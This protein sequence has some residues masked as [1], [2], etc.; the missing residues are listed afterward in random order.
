MLRVVLRLGCGALRGAT[1]GISLACAALRGGAE[2]LRYWARLVSNQRP[3]ACEAA[4]LRRSETASTS[5]MCRYLPRSVRPADHQGLRAIAGDSGRET[6][7]L[8]RDPRAHRLPPTRWSTSST[9]SSRPRRRSPLTEWAS[10][11]RSASCMPTSVIG[12]RL[13]ATSWSRRD[14]RPR[15]AT[16]RP[17]NARGDPSRERR[18]WCEPRLAAPLIEGYVGC[19][20]ISPGGSRELARVVPDPLAE[21]KPT[22]DTERAIS[23]SG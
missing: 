9:R 23:Q 19:V 20:V 13:P 5:G 18:L 15:I 12:P 14:R 4:I 17:V 1:A 21:W 10:S 6:G 16:A 11:R 2:S 7:F 8:P 22:R 3:L